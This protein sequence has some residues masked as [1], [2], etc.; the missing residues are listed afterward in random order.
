[1][2]C[3]ALPEQCNDEYLEQCTL[4]KAKAADGTIEWVDDRSKARFLAE[5]ASCLVW[6]TVK[7]P[8]PPASITNAF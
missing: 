3:L 8:P 7:V 2:S 5:G 1:M 6:N 4:K